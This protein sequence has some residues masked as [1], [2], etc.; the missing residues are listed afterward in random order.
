MGGFGTAWVVH[1]LGNFLPGAGVGNILVA[2][3]VM[4]YSKTVALLTPSS[5]IPDNGTTRVSE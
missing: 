2:T 1:L 3:D 4:V 5:K